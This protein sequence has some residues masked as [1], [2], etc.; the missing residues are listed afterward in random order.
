MCEDFPVPFLQ[1]MPG[2]HVGD[3]IRVFLKQ[4]DAL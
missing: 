2:G 4:D 3:E 1:K